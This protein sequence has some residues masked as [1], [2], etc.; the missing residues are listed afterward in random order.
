MDLDTL[1]SAI[2]GSGGI[3]VQF[4][5]FLPELVKMGVGIVTI[6]Y[7]VYKIMLIKK[8]LKE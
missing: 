5:D 4:M 1:K 3:T 8:Q 7:F 2:I 6:V